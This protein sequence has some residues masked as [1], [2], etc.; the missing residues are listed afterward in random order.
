[1][2]ILELLTMQEFEELNTLN[3]DK[4]E[5]IYASGLPLGRPAAA[6]AWILERRNEP[7]AE[8]A[9]F[10]AMNMTHIKKVIEGHTDPKD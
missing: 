2:T 5:V 4:F 7:K 1:M 9:T 10:L 3:G 6:L 8:L